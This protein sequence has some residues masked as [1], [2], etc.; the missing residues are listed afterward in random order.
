M[1]PADIIGVYQGVV[2]SSGQYWE[3][4]TTFEIDSAGELVGR[5]IYDENGGPFTGELS[6]VRLTDCHKI[7]TI[8][9]ETLGS[10]VL[11]A[12]FSEDFRTFKGLWSSLEDDDAVYPWVGKR[13]E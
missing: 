1:T 2:S 6:R 3:I 5:Y 9:S 12:E 8:W 4:T 13:L 7:V 10:G 11:E